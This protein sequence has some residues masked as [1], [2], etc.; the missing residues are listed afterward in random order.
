MHRRSSKPVARPDGVSCKFRQYGVCVPRGRP[1]VCDPTFA[2]RETLQRRGGGWFPTGERL[3][4]PRRGVAAQSAGGLGD[5]RERLQKISAPARP[6]RRRVSSPPRDGCAEPRPGGVCDAVSRRGNRRR[7]TGGRPGRERCLLGGTRCDAL[8][9]RGPGTVRNPVADVALRTGLRRTPALPDG[10]CFDDGHR[11]C[12]ANGGQASEQPPE[13]WHGATSARTCPGRRGFSSL[14]SR[15]AAP[16]PG[17]LRSA[18]GRLVCKTGASGT[19]CTGPT[20]LFFLF[21]KHAD[22]QGAKT[23]AGDG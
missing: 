20:E 3:P 16:R 15:C 21:Q 2:E 10:S 19:K 1:A 11:V 13:S 22:T 23:A 5:N 12:A 6:G 17:R 14:R 7:P 8:G 9:S 4:S 18:P